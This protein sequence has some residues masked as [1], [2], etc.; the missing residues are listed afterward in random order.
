LE[1]LFAAHY[2]DVLAYALRRSDGEAAQDVV[3]ETF[4]V[5][6]RRLEV[7]PDDAL[8]WLYGVARRV[9]ANQRRSDRRRDAL[10]QRLAAHAAPT[11][12]PAV[13]G[14]VSLLR[15]LARLSEQDCEALMLVAWEGLDRRRA[16][17]ALGCRPGTLGV[18]L[19][20]ARRRLARLL[21]QEEAPL[22]TA[23]SN[24]PGLEQR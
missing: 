14:D 7:V 1:A 20:R 12:R 17:A 19:H 10:A 8:P 18:R 24:P 21:D 11:D 3:A 13:G 23:A 22:G 6:W 4:L 15:A 2:D 5:A 9:L 16:A